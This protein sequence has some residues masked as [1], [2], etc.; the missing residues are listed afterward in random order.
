MNYRTLGQTG[1]SISEIGLGAYPISGMW[2]RPD[3][4]D[5]GWTGVDDS[6]S[7]DLIHR[8]QDLGINLIDTA[9]IY[10]DGH[11]ES[12][13]GKALIGRRDDWVIATKVQPNRGID[14]EAHDENAVRR[15]LTEACEASLRRLQTEAI[16]VYQLHAVPYA[17]A[18]P[19]VMETLAR[20]KADGK[21][22]WYGISTNNW[23][24]I[25]QL[26]VFGPIHVL[27]IG[28]NL[29]ERSADE[30]LH[31]A[32]AEEIGTLIRVPLAKGMLSGKYSGD[33]AATL[34]DQRSALRPLQPAGDRRRARQA[35]PARLSGHARAEHGAGFAA[36]C[37]RPPRRLLRHRRGQEPSADRGERGLVRFAAAQPRRAGP[38]PAHRRHH[39]D[40][41]LDLN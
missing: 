16:D 8:S 18:M 10:G 1:L 20:L 19:V 5:F 15:R 11:S 7:I 31:W 34:A 32:K 28:Y 22:R 23:D 3:G 36:F 33:N 38:G 27:Q 17:W 26:M 14:A 30:L 9:E 39:S 12:L 6:E 29:L 35:A 40:A 37:P 13:I 41:G 21:I 25:R 24:A 2:R 4:S